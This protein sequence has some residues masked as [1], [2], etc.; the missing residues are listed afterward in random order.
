MKALLS[1]YRSVSIR[2]NIWNGCTNFTYFTSCLSVPLS[3][4]ILAYIAYAV[5]PPSGLNYRLLPRMCCIILWNVSPTGLSSASCLNL[6]VCL[7]GLFPVLHCLPLSLI[8]PVNFLLFA[9]LIPVLYQIHFFLHLPP[10]VGV[11]RHILTP[12][13]YPSSIFIYSPLSAKSLLSFPSPI[14]VPEDFLNRH[15]LYSLL[16]SL[17]MRSPL[18]L[19]LHYYFLIFHGSLYRTFLLS[20]PPI[21][22][23]SSEP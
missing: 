2:K 14:L 15:A 22:Q 16:L 7:S 10:S 6:T 13:Y 23:V 18:S 11:T 3:F 12:D 17:F 21:Q 20:P 9:F 4:L 5:H 1:T 19:L 8:I